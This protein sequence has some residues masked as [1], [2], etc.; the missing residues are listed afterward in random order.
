[1]GVKTVPPGVSVVIPTNRADR[2]LPIAVESVLQQEGVAL[3]VV[4]VLDAVELPTDSWTRDARVKIVKRS[5][6]EGPAAA[7]QDGVDAAKYDYIARLD[8]DDVCLP[9][10]LAV[11]AEYL[12]QNPETVAV[13]CRTIRI[14]EEG[15]YQADI[16]LP[17]GR[18]IRKSLAFYNVVPHSTLMFRATAARQVGGYDRNLSTMEDYEFILRLALIGPIAQLAERLVEYRIH[19]GQSSLG[20]PARGEHIERIVRLRHEL[21]SFL[22]LPGGRLWLSNV[23]WR[24]AQFSRRARLL[25]PHHLH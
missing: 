19:A 11:E 14:D 9:S 24:T 22:G 25:K 13:S 4:V 17:S 16:R 18:D 10:R 3:E 23:V 2:W 21:G 6:S 20:A 12:Q 7:M 8:S 15:R 1:M 5:I